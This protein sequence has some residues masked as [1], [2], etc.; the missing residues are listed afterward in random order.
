[1]SYTYLLNLP[2][3]SIRVRFHKKEQNNSG[4]R[5]CSW[6]IILHTS[7]KN[8]I[9]W[10]VSSTV[11]MTLMFREPDSFL[12]TW[13]HL[14]SEKIVFNN[15]NSVGLYYTHRGTHIF[16]YALMEVSWIMTLEGNY[17]RARQW[18]WSTAYI[19]GLLSKDIIRHELVCGKWW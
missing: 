13:F 5:K 6:R 8:L 9:N 11:P 16:L 19:A 1:M 17:L 12:K 4:S 2:L 10:K 18:Y 7:M 15:A 14:K 3:A